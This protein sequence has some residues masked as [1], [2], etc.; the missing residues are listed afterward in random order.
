MCQ[1]SKG[2]DFLQ[3]WFSFIDHHLDQFV[4]QNNKLIFTP[5]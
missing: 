5:I 2:R 4:D 3:I 1:H